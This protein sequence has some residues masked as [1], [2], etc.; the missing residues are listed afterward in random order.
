M[1]KNFILLLLLLLLLLLERTFQNLEILYAEETGMI[2]ALFI[3]VGKKERGVFSSN[4]LKFI[5]KVTHRHI[6][7]YIHRAG[8]FNIVLPKL[9][10]GEISGKLIL[11][12]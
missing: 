10:P 4:I 5:G 3:S 11:S 2:I 1:Y 12:P 9:G 7:A 6:Y 8:N